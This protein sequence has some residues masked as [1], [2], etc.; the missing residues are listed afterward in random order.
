M[1]LHTAADDAAVLFRSLGLYRSPQI[2]FSDR[3]AAAPKTT[4]DIGPSLLKLPNELLCQIAGHLVSTENICRKDGYRALYERKNNRDL[5]TTD[6]LRIHLWSI[7]DLLNLGLTC[8][9]LAPV[10]Q[11]ILYRDIFLPK[12][13]RM[14][15]P[16]DRGASSLVCFLRTIMRRPELG[17]HVRYLAVWFK[18]GKRLR[19][20]KTAND[21]AVCSCASCLQKLTDLVD[22]LRLSREAKM[23]WLKDLTRPTEATICSLIIA[24]LPKLQALEL[25]A[26]PLADEK[27]VRRLKYRSTKIETKHDN[28]EVLR[29]SQGLAATQVKSL[30]LSTGLNGLAVAR[31]PSLTSLTLD[32]T[33]PHQFVSIRKGCFLNVTN[34]NIRCRQNE[35]ES[36]AGHDPHYRSSF[37]AKLEILLRGLPRI[38]VLEFESGAA[39]SQCEIPPSVELIRFRGAEWD[40]LQWV[41]F[42]LREK[43]VSVIP[44]R[45]E[46]HCSKKSRDEVRW[47]QFDKWVRNTG[48]QVMIMWRGDIQA[49]FE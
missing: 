26:R 46:L 21:D 2:C 20:S 35:F 7:Q 30:T 27:Q 5:E 15:V 41:H 6:L 8:K 28:T 25:H 10:A 33:G 12:P 48:V 23:L 37:R 42:Y 11:D 3:T 19:S 36:M 44:R 4:G 17:A 9:R 45:I 29:L 39:A 38:R 43:E 22:T 16:G 1:A 34:L 24:S 13:R 40:A 32:Y 18:K 31:Q 14:S 47:M 49:V